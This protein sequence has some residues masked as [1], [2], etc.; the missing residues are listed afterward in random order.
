MYD[1]DFG[2]AQAYFISVRLRV[3]DNFSIVDF[4][5]SVSI[6]MMDTSALFRR[7]IFQQNNDMLIRCS[8]TLRE[9]YFTK[10]NYSPLKVF[11]DKV[12]SIINDVVLVKKID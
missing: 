6:R 1:V 11:F 10:E 7:E 4:P 3:A 9:P 2:C 12:Y 5:R 8:F